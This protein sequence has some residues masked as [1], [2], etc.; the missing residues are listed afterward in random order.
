MIMK[1][2][3]NRAVDQLGNKVKP[4]VDDLSCWLLPSQNWKACP[5]ENKQVLALSFWEKTTLFAQQ[6]A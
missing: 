6:N 3:W 4:K 1:Q 2:S 5:R